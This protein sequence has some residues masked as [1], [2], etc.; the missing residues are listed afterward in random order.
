M[1]ASFFRDSSSTHSLQG[2]TGKEDEGFKS[3]GGG[4]S[5]RRFLEQELVPYV[6]K[7]FS[8]SA[9]RIYCG[10]SF[11]G[12]SVIDEL[13]DESSVFDALLMIDPS[14]G[15]GRGVSDGIF[16]QGARCQFAGGDLGTD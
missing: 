2:F 3:S 10:Y 14:C 15:V 11:T 12:L 1:A 7:E 13:L 4:E 9:Y 16:H 8:T 6:D 5:F